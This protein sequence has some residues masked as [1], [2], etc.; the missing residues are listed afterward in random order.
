MLLGLAVLSLRKDN[1]E[2]GDRVLKGIDAFQA[3]V[4]RLVRMVIRLTPYGVLALMTRVVATSNVNDVI[5]LGTFVVASYLGMGI[6][7]LDARRHP[8]ARPASARCAST[9]RSGRC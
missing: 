9:R 7:L 6:I 8:G 5:N 4:L 3:L 2:L 1:P